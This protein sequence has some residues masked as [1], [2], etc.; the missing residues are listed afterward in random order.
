VSGEQFV[1]G[2]LYFT[3][4]SFSGWIAE[5]AYI[6]F[7]SGQWVNRGFLRGPLIPV[8]GCGSLL[9]IYAPQYIQNV[10][11]RYAPWLD[12]N[13]RLTPVLALLLILISL[14]YLTD[15]GLETLFHMKWRD[16]STKKFNLAGRVSLPRSFW[17]IFPGIILIFVIHPAFSSWMERTPLLWRATAA[18]LIAILFAGDALTS[19]RRARNLRRMMSELETL[20]MILYRKLHNKQEEYELTFWDYE[21]NKGVRQ[22]EWR[23]SM[24]EAK[25]DLLRQPE[26]G[27]EAHDNRIKRANEELRDALRSMKEEIAEAG[28]RRDAARREYQENLRLRIDEK[29]DGI[30]S[31]REL[32][33]MYRLFRAFP[34]LTSTKEPTVLSPKNTRSSTRAMLTP[35]LSVIRYLWLE[36]RAVMG[37]RC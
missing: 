5:C 30:R 7:K 21:F 18:G 26:G 14:E 32:K 4:Y 1:T 17:W 34:G 28:E 8:Y 33:N 9:L 2:L 25:A 36:V 19:V 6:R 3:A 23:Q 11:R 10:F 27:D 15:W 13:R 12:I 29:L 22:R 20:A 24:D 35:D 31:K 16:C 37:G